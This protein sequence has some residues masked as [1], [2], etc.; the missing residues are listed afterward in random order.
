MSTFTLLC[1]FLTLK[2][3]FSNPFHMVLVRYL[4]LLVDMIYTA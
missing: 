2:G 3:V 4:E 1:L